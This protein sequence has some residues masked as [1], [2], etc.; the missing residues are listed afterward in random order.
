MKEREDQVMKVSK[1]VISNLT[2][3]YSIAPLT[4]QGKRHILVA[5]EKQDP[6]Y[7]FDLEGNQ[8]ETVWEG[9][10]GVMSM[11]QVPGSDGVFLATHKFYSPN[12]HCIAGTRRNLGNPYAGRSSARTSV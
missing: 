6:C 5:A 8:E 10:G 3:C 2:K 1:K 7:L 12:D 9:P 11:V 4:Y